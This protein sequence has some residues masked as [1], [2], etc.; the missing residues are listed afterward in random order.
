MSRMVMV[1]ELSSNPQPYVTSSK[2]IQ[3]YVASSVGVQA[4]GSLVKSSVCRRCMSAV[5]PEYSYTVLAPV[6]IEATPAS[7]FLLSCLLCSSGRLLLLLLFHLLDSLIN[8]H[9][10]M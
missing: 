7:S 1:T 3:P 10:R 6:F 8:L 4:T 2:R 9:K 5:S